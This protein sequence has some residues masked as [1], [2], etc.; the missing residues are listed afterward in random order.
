M[1]LSS[2]ARTFLQ[3]CL[4]CANNGFCKQLMLSSFWHD[5]KHYALVPSKNRKIHFHSPSCYLFQWVFQWWIEP[6][7]SFNLRYWTTLQF[8]FTCSLRTTVYRQSLYSSWTFRNLH[9]FVPFLA[10]ITTVCLIGGPLL[11]PASLSS[12]IVVKI[13]PFSVVTDYAT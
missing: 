8:K 11:E 3:S 5:D 2:S 7:R 12:D 1:S 10:L 13:D 4:L 9:L 6:A